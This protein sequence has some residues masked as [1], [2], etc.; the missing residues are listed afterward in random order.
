MYINQTY[1]I[2]S[3]LFIGESMIVFHGIGQCWIRIP[4]GAEIQF[5]VTVLLKRN[6]K[7]LSYIIT[8]K[9]YRLPNALMRSPLDIVYRH[10]FLGWLN[11]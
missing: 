5:D 7:C 1:T 11:I 2:T 4:C 10:I 3:C 6:A 9:L 8:L